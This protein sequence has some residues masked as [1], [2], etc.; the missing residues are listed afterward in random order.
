MEQRGDIA[1]RARDGASFELRSGQ[2]SLMVLA[3]RHLDLLQLQS[4]L[5]DHVASAPALLRGAPVVLDL[6]PLSQ[7]ADHGLLRELVGRIHQ[8]GLRVIAMAA[9][10]GAE[11]AAHALDLPLLGLD[12]RRTRVVDAE[13]AEP[14][15]EEVPAA[16]AEPPKPPGPPGLQPPLVLPGPIRSGQQ[17]YARGRDLIIT[18]VVSAGAEVAADGCV[19]VYGRLMGKALAGASGDVR[20]R[21]YCL[22]FGAEVAS[23]AGNFKVFES[24]P[25]DVAGKAVE[26]HLD[27]GRL[28]IRPLKV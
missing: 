11:A 6:N 28:E 20:A 7:L 27:E 10:P 17:V 9:N 15:A 2:F 21:I 1:T 18:G 22:A 4:E 23:I 13:P 5:S 12:R 14:V 3:I 24:A 8:A 16:D 26:I 25:R 19:H